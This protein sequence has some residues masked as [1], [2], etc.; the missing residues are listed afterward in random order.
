MENGHLYWIFPLQ[1]VIFH[2][3]VSSPECICWDMEF[4]QLA[5]H[6]WEFDGFLVEDHG[7]IAEIDMGT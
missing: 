2:C 6:Q 7:D 5:G 4:D 3:Y 1:M